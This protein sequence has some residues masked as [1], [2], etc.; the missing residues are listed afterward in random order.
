MPA[1][2][3]LERRGGCGFHCHTADIWPVLRARTRHHRSVEWRRSRV[4]W[5]DALPRLAA[6]PRFAMAPDPGRRA[7]CIASST[8]LQ[9]RVTRNRRRTRPAAG[10]PAVSWPPPDRRASLAAPQG[11]QRSGDHPTTDRAQLLI[12][13]RDDSSAQQHSS[14]CL[15]VTQRTGQMS[16]RV[17]RTRNCTRQHAV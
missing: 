12:V 16:R 6:P 3:E 15:L 8:C 5:L 9:A 17:T 10:L 13:T 2:G 7:A 4:R 1:Y 11:R 14:Q